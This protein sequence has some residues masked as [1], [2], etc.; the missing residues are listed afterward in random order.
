L[1]QARQIWL[2]RREPAKEEAVPK[3]PRQRRTPDKNA[4]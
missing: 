3:A 1:A 4:A 2:H